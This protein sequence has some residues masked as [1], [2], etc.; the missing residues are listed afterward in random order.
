MKR[1]NTKHII[2]ALIVTVLLLIIILTIYGFFKSIEHNV[3]TYTQSTLDEV[4]TLQKDAI[5]DRLISDMNMIE[6]LAL[7]FQLS[8]VS[9]EQAMELTTHAIT[10]MDLQKIILFD[11]NGNGQSSDGNK[12]SAEELNIFD[13]L[14]SRESIIYEAETDGQEECVIKMSAPVFDKENGE[15]KY[16]IVGIYSLDKIQESIESTFS[17]EDN[18]GIINSKGELI[19]SNRLT[20]EFFEDSNMAE[21]LEN[22]VDGS[23]LYE[24]NGAH[25]YCKYTNLG[26]NNWFVVGHINQSALSNHV[27]FNSKDLAVMLLVI[28]MCILILLSYILISRNKSKR[29]LANLALYDKITS[30]PTGEKFKIDI[31][32]L[33]AEKGSIQSF[34]VVFDICNF[35][36]I[37]DRFGNKM[38]DEMLRKIADVMR[39]IEKEH[40]KNT[41]FISK[42]YSDTFAILITDVTNEELIE[43]SWKF[44]EKC[45]VESRFIGEYNLN[46]SCGRYINQPEDTADIIL[47][48]AVTAHAHSKNQKSNTFVDYDEEFMERL[49][50]QSDIMNSFSNALENE[51]FQIYLQPQYKAS[52]EKISGAEVLVRWIKDGKVKYTPNVFIPVLEDSG[53]ISELDSYLREQICQSIRK[54]SDA[55]MYV[56]PISLNVSRI[57]LLEKDFVAKLLKLIHKYDLQPELLHI[58]ITETAYVGDYEYLTNVVAEL[59]E[60]GFHVEMDDFGSGYSSLNVLKDIAIDTVKLDMKF[61]EKG[62]NEAKSGSILSSVVRMT[63]G[64]DLLTIAEGVEIRAQIDYLRSIGCDFMQ[65]YYFAKPMPLEEFEKLLKG[66]EVQVEWKLER[67]IGIDDAAN[68]LN[69]TAQETLLFNTFSGGAAIVEYFNDEMNVIR[70]NDKCFE[71]FAKTRDTYNVFQ[72][73][74]FDAIVPEFR[75]YIKSSL[76]QSIETGEEITGECA[77]LPITEEDGVMWQI[78]SLRCIGRKGKRYLFYLVL[79]DITERKRL[80]ENLTL[81]IKKSKDIIESM[82]GGY[83]QAKIENGIIK[84]IDVSKGICSRLEYTAE[85]LCALEDFSVIIDSKELEKKMIEEGTYVATEIR[86]ISKSGEIIW[87]SCTG[88]YQRRDEASGIFNGLFFDINPY[89]KV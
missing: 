47:E 28:G 46:F 81:E 27:E 6:S 58:E 11:M 34:C 14:Y 59:S 83:I 29:E 49:H 19:F 70:I 65:G 38:G 20:K 2:N 40:P 71:V 52:D 60:N 61:V 35:K 12:I 75:E 37:N 16:V 7:S 22:G 63:Q 54:W 41:L 15:I 45:R 43:K 31:N 44:L 21:N 87:F 80:E 68:F 77:T 8:N 18:I 84:V 23:F 3:T 76:N 9:F 89:K 72:F 33:L 24:Y 55:D 1:S 5:Y 25:Y 53:R 56:V 78:F 30:L 32:K 79:T 67:P 51:E 48:R 39:E 73:N 64:I 4:I 57:E 85:E 36:L 10:K 26:I 86:L 17:K 42:L 66:E 74:L 88:K 13:K 62:K 82:P 69:A 50:T